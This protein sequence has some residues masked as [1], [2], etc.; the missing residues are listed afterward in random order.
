MYYLEPY[1][2]TP[3]YITMRDV[4]TALNIADYGVSIAGVMGVDTTPADVG[5]FAAQATRIIADPYSVEKPVNE[6]TKL[7]ASGVSIRFGE[8]TGKKRTASA[9]DL[10]AK[11]II[12]LTVKIP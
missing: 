7:I 3:K 6:T 9:I 11:G 8:A 4:D 10:I 12:D 2:R 5:L 1:R